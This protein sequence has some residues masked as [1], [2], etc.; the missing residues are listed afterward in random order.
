MHTHADNHSHIK[1]NKRKSNIGNNIA[2][3][4]EVR[5]F[6]KYTHHIKTKQSA[7]IS[8]VSV[9]TGHQLHKET[10]RCTES[11]SAEE[12]DTQRENNR[13]ERLEGNWRRVKW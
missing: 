3:P 5:S 7:F 4:I 9:T 13:G 10:K 11:Q 6:P 1:D 12:A 2:F 8:N